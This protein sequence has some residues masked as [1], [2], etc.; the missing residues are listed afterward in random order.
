M[1]EPQCGETSLPFRARKCAVLLAQV[2]NLAVQEIKITSCFKL[3]AQNE[4]TGLAKTSYVNNVIMAD[5]NLLPSKKEVTEEF[6]IR[7]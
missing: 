4:L 5:V 3:V 2:V 6:K 1:L 7:L